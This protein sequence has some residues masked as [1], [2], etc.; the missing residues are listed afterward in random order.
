VVKFVELGAIAIKLGGDR[1][2]VFAV[3]TAP[4]GTRKVWPSVEGIKFGELRGLRPA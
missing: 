1:A 4:A 3:K 2:D